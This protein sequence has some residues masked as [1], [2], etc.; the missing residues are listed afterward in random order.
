MILSM[1]KT[2]QALFLVAL[3]AL[4]TAQASSAAGVQ[5]NAVGLHGY[6]PVAYFADH[7]ARRG[8]NGYSA[9]HDGVVYLFANEDNL[10]AFKKNPA[11]Y[12]PQYGGYCAMGVSLGYKLPIDPEAW[13]V[14]D[15]KLYLNVSKKV[16]ETW[17][18]DVPGNIAK[19]NTNW[20]DIRDIPIDQ[21][22]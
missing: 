14:V 18:K 22:K 17:L 11:A 7:K 12:L 4:A 5:V 3:A 1:K 6:D 13:E 2:L 15:G 10:N 16:K 9:A 8:D 21:F 19:A 20:P